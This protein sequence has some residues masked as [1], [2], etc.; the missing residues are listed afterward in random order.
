LTVFSEIIKIVLYKHPRNN[1]VLRTPGVGLNQSRLML[2]SSAGGYPHHSQEPFDTASVFGD[3]TIR[4]FPTS[5]PFDDLAYAH[6]IS[7]GT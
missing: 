7:I 3:Y 6:A 2:I 5:T 1:Q 4:T